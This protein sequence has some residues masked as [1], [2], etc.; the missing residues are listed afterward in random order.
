MRKLI[1]IG[2]VML[3]GLS[4]CGKFETVDP[5]RVNCCDSAH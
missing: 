4:G 3:A 1:P 5:L 2:I